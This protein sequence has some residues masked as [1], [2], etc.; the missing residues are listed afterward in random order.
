MQG[1]VS[2]SYRNDAAQRV[3]PSPSSVSTYVLYESRLDFRSRARS[4]P[5]GCLVGLGGLNGASLKCRG[6][7]VLL[8]L[9]VRKLRP[10]LGDG[11]VMRHDHAALNQ[12][13][14]KGS[15]LGPGCIRKSRGRRTAIGMKSDQRR[16][17]G[18]RAE[19]RKKEACQREFWRDPRSWA[20]FEWKA[21]WIG[22]EGQE[23]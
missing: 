7:H 18:S 23:L 4:D 11:G 3:H 1:R 8:V 9:V 20:S 22:G 16:R 15:R 13:T 10:Y 21:T 19:G 17:W 6:R 2:S 14:R 12:K 5:K